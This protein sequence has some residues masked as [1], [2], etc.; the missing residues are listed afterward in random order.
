M[1]AECAYAYRV[2]AVVP[3][4]SWKYAEAWAR[5]AALRP[6]FFGSASAAAARAVAMIRPPTTSTV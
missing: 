3:V 5:A 1:P 6:A 2:S 4:F